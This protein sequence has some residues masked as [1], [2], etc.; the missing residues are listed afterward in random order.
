MPKLRKTNFMFLSEKLC[1]LFQ[2]NLALFTNVFQKKFGTESNMEFLSRKV[3]LETT[4]LNTNNLNEITLT[5]FCLIV[6]T[7][8][9][10]MQSVLNKSL[11]SFPHIAIRFRFD[12]ALLEAFHKSFQTWFLKKVKFLE[13]IDAVWWRTTAK[14]GGSRFVVSQNII[15]WLLSSQ[16]SESATRLS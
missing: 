5:W 8:L 12:Y 1:C 14:G 16:I 13:Q 6:V 9:S 2:N 4:T 15:K 10:D 11:L 3:L 7:S